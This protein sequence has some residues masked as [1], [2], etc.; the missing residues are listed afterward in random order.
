ML[1]MRCQMIT[2]DIETRLATAISTI[3]KN[4]EGSQGELYK[5]VEMVISIVDEDTTVMILDNMERFND[6]SSRVERTW[7]LR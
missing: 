1:D 7:P 5:R 6:V 4:P 2:A 3:L